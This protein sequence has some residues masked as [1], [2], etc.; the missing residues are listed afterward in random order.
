P[1]EERYLLLRDWTLPTETRRT[2]RLIGA[3]SGGQQV[4]PAFLPRGPLAP[5]AEIPLAEREDHIDGPADFEPISNFTLLVQ[6][7]EQSGKLGELAAAIEPCLAEKLPGAE[8]L[9][10]I[11]QIAQRDFAPVRQRLDALRSALQAEANQQRPAAGGAVDP[12]GT[13]QQPKAVSWS[14]YLAAH[15]ALKTPQ[16]AGKGRL[17]M[18]EVAAVGRRSN[19]SEMLAHAA[20]DIA[21]FQAA[22][23]GGTDLRSLEKGQLA[24]WHPNNPAT[25]VLL[26]QVPRVWVAHDGLLAH[27]TGSSGDQL[28]FKSPLAGEFQ[29]SYELFFSDRSYGG[30]G[31]AGLAASLSQWRDGVYISPASSHEQVNRS[32]PA[33]RYDGW[34][35]ME[36]RVTPKSV[37]Y[38]LNGHPIYEEAAPSGTSPWL[39]L[40]APGDSTLKMRNL[41]LRGSP[42]IPRE[43]RLVEGD[44]FDGWSA[45]SY[46]ERLPKRISKNE[47]QNQY[48]EDPYAYEESPRRP[49]EPLPDWTAADGE[50]VGR[51]DPLAAPDAQSR[52]DYHRPLQDGDRVRYEFFYEPQ[53]THV[54]PA[55]GRVA[56]VLAEEGLRL[57]WMTRPG[58]NA[59]EPIS[60]DPRNML[61]DRD[62]RRG[63]DK[64]PLVAGDWNQVEL[65]L[66]G[67]EV[68]LTLNGTEILRRAI[69]PTNDRRFGLFR[70]KSETTARVRNVV[71]SGNWPVELT[72][73]ERANLL[74]PA[75]AA[76]DAEKLARHRIIGEEH[77]THDAYAVWRR[78]ASLPPEERYKLLA[79]WVLPSKEHPTFRLRA[80]F[81]PT[82]PV[83]PT[84]ADA[85]TSG[86]IH[87]GGEIVSPAAELVAAAAELGRLDE[88]AKEIEAAASSQG[89]TKEERSVLALQLLLDV[90]RKDDAAAGGRLKR[91]AALAKD[92]PP[93]IPVHQRYGDMVAVRA[94]LDR[95]ALRA[96]ALA[97][98]EQLVASPVSKGPLT[99]WWRPM[100]HRLL[101]LARGWND[102]DAGDR[103]RT[104]VPPGL[105]QWI[106]V[107]HPTAAGRGTGAPLPSWRFTRGQTDFLTGNGR[108]ALYFRSPLTGD[109]ELRYQISTPENRQMQLLYG[110]TLLSLAPDGASLRRRR[111]G[112]AE[113]V[114]P[115][116]EKPALLGE[117][118]ELRLVVKDGALF[119]FVGDKQVHTERLEMHFDPWLAVRSAEPHFLGGMRNVQLLGSPTIPS[120]VRIF[121]GSDLAGGLAEYFGESVAGAGA[122]WTKTGDE[123]V[124]RSIVNS[125]GSFRESLLQYHRPLVE[126]GEVEYE[127]YYEP[128]KAEVH[129]ALDRLVFLLHPDGPRLHW[130]TSGAYGLRDGLAPDNS[131]PLAGAMPVPFKTRE[132]N[133]LK[134][135]LVTGEVVIAVNGQEVARRKLEASNLRTLGWFHYT[136]A[137]TARIR[138]VVYRGQWPTQLPPIDQQQLA[139]AA[140]K[141]D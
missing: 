73:D 36:V 62:A 11:V 105:T 42:V 93:H 135:T 107:N 1:P 28:I 83:P 126:D 35:R 87:T 38:V 98:A 48:Y 37:Q 121:A 91:L 44:R 140:A 67:D 16:I 60:I 25:V 45:S 64:L 84:A 139:A 15:V 5:R 4:P 106:A 134:L 27:A 101:G 114:V 78:S 130:L 20:Y 125:P 90:A 53:L 2:L 51:A 24:L 82:D 26:S 57:H 58:E 76:S 86:P 29:F 92:L 88:L 32:A 63:P 97:L 133:K 138:N 116:A 59:N 52:L 122:A 89:M 21:R 111:P 128:G 117:W 102:P 31:Y 66:A 74:A 54:H 9:M 39:C 104:S 61:E 75:A 95:P 79:A 46:N 132:W 129:P 124:G 40:S 68:S 33:L 80:D 100:A 7:A 85:Q 110:G 131:E 17:L 71:L 96:D 14:D 22:N 127:F 118:A 72:A 43:V 30:V 49:R 123:I 94:A 34:N 19:G 12:F 10:T 13:P 41:Q 65:A 56:L 18:N 3:F 23:A 8:G 120:E 47:R 109:F 99:N 55:L 112:Q 108:D 136:D 137:S 81:T 70:F 77:F 141:P 50:L 69:E 113:S 6:A 103:S 115:L 119:A